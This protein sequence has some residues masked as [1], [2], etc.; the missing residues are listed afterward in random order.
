MKKI[1][2]AT[3]LLIFV[4]STFCSCISTKTTLPNETTPQSSEPTSQTVETTKTK[5][6]EDTGLINRPDHPSDEYFIYMPLVLD[7][8]FVRDLENKKSE[9]QCDILIAM[10]DLLFENDTAPVREGYTYLYTEYYKKTDSQVDLPLDELHD[11]YQNSKGEGIAFIRGTD[12]IV[13]SYTPCNCSGGSS[14]TDVKKIAAQ[15]YLSNQLGND[16][17]EKYVQTDLKENGEKVCFKYTRYLC[18]Y[19]TRDII[20][21]EVCKCG[22]VIMCRM[23]NVNRYNN[24]LE[25]ISRRRVEYSYELLKSKVDGMNINVIN[26]SQPRLVISNTGEFF[27]EVSMTHI[28]TFSKPNTGMET[29]FSVYYKY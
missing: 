7:G 12:K 27:I 22:K 17:F 19:S 6:P 21:I 14:S 24:A 18:G 2:A 11:Y 10:D 5:L 3:L 13:Y 23:P 25:E 29:T 26:Y 16:V 4:L 1:F 28:D 8:W 20:E 9:R 15:V